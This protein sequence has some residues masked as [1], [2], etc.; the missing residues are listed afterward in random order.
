MSVYFSTLARR[1]WVRYCNSF[2][3]EAIVAASHP[4]GA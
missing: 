4:L 2:D 1:A 3:A